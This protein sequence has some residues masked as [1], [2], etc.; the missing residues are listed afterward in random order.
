MIVNVHQANRI[1][2]SFL[3]REKQE[4]QA[5]FANDA[6]L[7][8]KLEE[9]DDA[10][11]HLESM[12]Q[13]GRVPVATSARYIKTM[14]QG[15]HEWRCRRYSGKTREDKLADCNEAMTALLFL[16]ET[17]A[18]VEPEQLSLLG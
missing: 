1:L 2:L 17:L 16:H 15:E 14:I 11:K 4:R 10:M 13:G 9:C 6:K 3:Y 5:V 12:I 18:P 7:F 8:G